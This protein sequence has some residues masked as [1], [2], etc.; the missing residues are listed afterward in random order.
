MEGIS[1][2]VVLVYFI[3]IVMSILAKIFFKLG[4]VMNMNGSTVDYFIFL[5]SISIINT[6]TLI[7]HPYTTINQTILKSSK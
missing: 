4:Q 1:Q 3:I 7:S 2:F 6:T 5:L